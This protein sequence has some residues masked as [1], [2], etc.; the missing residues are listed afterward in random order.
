MN[1]FVIDHPMLWI[2]LVALPLLIVVLVIWRCRPWIRVLTVV[3]GIL[4]SIG[5]TAYYSSQVA[6]VCNFLDRKNFILLPVE[7]IMNDIHSTVNRGDL[8][9]TKAQLTEFQSSWNAICMTTNDPWIVQERI[10][11]MGSKDEGKANNPTQATG[12]P[13]PGR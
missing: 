4:W 9:L 1:G 3:L 11:G 2:A 13:A 12:K 8:E 10:A 6:E 5:T 7:S